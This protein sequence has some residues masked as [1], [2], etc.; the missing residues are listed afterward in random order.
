MLKTVKSQRDL[1]EGQLPQARRRCQSVQVSEWP[2]QS[3]ELKLIKNLGKNW[4]ADCDRFIQCIGAWD[5][6]QKRSFSFYLGNVC[7]DILF[8][9]AEWRM[10]SLSAR[11]TF[12][13]FYLCI[14]KCTF[15]VFYFTSKHCFVLVI[16]I[17]KLKF[18]LIYITKCKKFQV[19]GLNLQ[20]T[21]CYIYIY[22]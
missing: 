14:L 7:R 21:K 3:P 10:K 20:D 12:S 4:K 18:V 2:S 6:L 17:N 9:D 11:C 8:V 19:V 13:N 16:P 22:N 1:S 5:I 15:F